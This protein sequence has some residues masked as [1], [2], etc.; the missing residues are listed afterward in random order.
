VLLPEGASAEAV[1]WAGGLLGDGA[2]LVTYAWLCV[3]ED[4]ALVERDLLPAV[5]VWRGGGLYP[6]LVARA[7][8]AADGPLDAAAVRA[9]AV[10]GGAG[11]CADAVVARAAAG[12]SLVV[13]APVGERPLEQLERFAE[14]V[15]P[16]L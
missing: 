14:R 4:G 7:G 2:T 3:D 6:N 13:L 5:A 16:R 8:A 15:L 11:E 10:A 12:A 1:A 9:V